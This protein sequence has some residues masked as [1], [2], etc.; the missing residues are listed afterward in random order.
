MKHYQGSWVSF[1]SF[2]FAFLTTLVLQKKTRRVTCQKPLRNKRSNLRSQATRFVFENKTSLGKDRAPAPTV[3]CVSPRIKPH[4]RENP[5]SLC[6]LLWPTD[7][8]ANRENW[9]EARL[10]RDLLQNYSEWAR[11]VTDPSLAVNVYFFMY[12]Y[13]L[14]DVVSLFTVRKPGF[15]KGL[16]SVMKL[17]ILLI[18]FWTVWTLEQHKSSELNSTHH[19]G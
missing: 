5:L 14:N 1:L 19:L 11:P 17:S 15:R 4:S 13:Q 18:S 12:L 3:G 9:T 7:T 2:F 10:I 8:A 16:F 6:Q